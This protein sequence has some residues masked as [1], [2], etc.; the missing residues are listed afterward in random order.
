TSWSRSTSYH[1]H[2]AASAYRSGSSSNEYILSTPLLTI[3]AGSS[4]DFWA[5]GSN[6]TSGINIVY[7]S[8]REN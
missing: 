4:L 1:I 3:E 5:A 6:A 7:S 8:D 2:G